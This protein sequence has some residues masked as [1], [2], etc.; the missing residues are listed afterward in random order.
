MRISNIIKHEHDIFINGMP[1]RNHFCAH[2][3]TFSL[4][5][6]QNNGSS[7]GLSSEKRGIFFSIGVSMR[8]CL[9]HGISTPITHIQMC[10]AD[11]GQMFTDLIIIELIAVIGVLIIKHK[12][13]P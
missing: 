10:R 13:K 12:I 6:K 9:S 4:A 8:V 5:D 11:W 3:E 1:L 2:T 7:N